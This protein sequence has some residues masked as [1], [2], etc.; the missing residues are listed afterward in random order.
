MAL[1]AIVWTYLR[2]RFHANQNDLIFFVEYF[3]RN[4]HAFDRCR[5]ASVDRPAMRTQNRAVLPSERP[6]TA[7]V[8]RDARRPTYSN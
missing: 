6:P 7:L 4:G 3:L 8:S 5:E 1:D 2:K